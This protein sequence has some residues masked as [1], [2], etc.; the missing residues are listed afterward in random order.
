MKNISVKVLLILVVAFGVIA[1]VMLFM[2]KVAAP[3]Y[4]VSKEN[5]YVAHFDDDDDAPA[6]IEGGETAL[7]ADLDLLDNFYREKKIERSDY[8][9]LYDSTSH[10]FLEDYV[11]RSFA[12]FR[13]PNWS[14]KSIKEIQ[15]ESQSFGAI[16]R[17]D[18]RSIATLMPDIANDFKRIETIISDYRKALALSRSATFQG[19]DDANRRISQANA[20]I[21]SDPLNNNTVLVQSLKELPKRLCSSHFSQLNA[22][23]KKLSGIRSPFDFDADYDRLAKEIDRF[24]NWSNHGVDGVPGMLYKL[25]EELDGADFYGDAELYA[26]ADSIAEY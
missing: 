26:P 3:P 18:G 24:G 6:Q 13:Q 16:K 14:E 15:R 17:N 5:P 1:G 2:K 22:K 11:N 8:N 10:P 21:N 7:R 25:E 19:W 12:F 23:I 4:E 9:R 20:Y